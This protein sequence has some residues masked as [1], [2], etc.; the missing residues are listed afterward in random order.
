MVPKPAPT[1]VSGVVVAL[2]TQA[3]VLLEILTLKTV[4][5]AELSAK[6]VPATVL[7]TT[8]LPVR[9]PEIAHPE[10]VVPVQGRVE[11][12]PKL[13][14]T[15]VSGA[16]AA[17]PTQV[18]VLPEI[19]TLKT[20]GIAELN[21]EPVPTPVLG[22]TGLLVREPDLVLPGKPGIVPEPVVLGRRDATTNVPGAS[23]TLQTPESAARELKE[24]RT[25]GTV[26]RR[27]A[28]AR[29]AVHGNSGVP[30]ETRGNVLPMTARRNPVLMEVQ[31]AE[32]AAPHVVGASGM[33]VHPIAI[34]YENIL[35]V[36]HYGQ[37]VRVLW[38]TMQSGRVNHQILLA[39]TLTSPLLSVR[40]VVD[41]QL[42]FDIG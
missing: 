24:T 29:A 21:A 6:P 25:V 4:G 22:T 35:P 18:S 39:I 20:A 31:G 8:G 30:A 9:K 11:M 16:V 5:I 19:L 3:N 27:V 42:L 40:V 15:N 23:V 7:G 2:P 14:L 13:V 36:V 28:P 33:I 26:A 34:L 17:L 37:E 38:I 12:V 41:L 1:N 10:I 32:P